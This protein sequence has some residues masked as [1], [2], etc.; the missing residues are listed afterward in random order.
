MWLSV[1]RTDEESAEQL[2]YSG[3]DL[4]GLSL[5]GLN[6]SSVNFSDSRFDD[7]DLSGCNLS[8]EKHIFQEFCSGGV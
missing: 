5:A 8:G 1:N 3:C 6:L 7:A 2:N 4:S